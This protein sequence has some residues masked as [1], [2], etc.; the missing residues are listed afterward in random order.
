M[1]YL[2]YCVML[3]TRSLLRQLLAGPT[4]ETNPIGA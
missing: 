4:V 3:P 1:F 2:Q